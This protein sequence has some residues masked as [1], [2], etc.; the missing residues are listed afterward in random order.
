M[1]NIFKIEQKT[2]KSIKWSFFGELIVKLISPIT[3]MV[4]ARLLAPEVFGIVATISIVIALSE[5]LADSGFSKAIVQ[6][7]YKTKEDYSKSTTTAFW[8]TLGISLLIFVIVAIFR[9]PI[10]YL[11]GSPGY[12]FALLIASI[13][14][15]IYSLSSVHLSILR[16]NFLF[17][18]IFWVRFAAA[19]VPLAFGTVLALIRLSYWSLIIS[20]LASITIQSVLIIFLSKW[21][22]TLSFSFPHLKSM[23][24]YSFLNLLEALLVWVTASIDLVIISYVFG[25]SLTGMYRLSSTTVQALVRLVTAVF[26][27]VLFSS[28]S[29][30]KDDEF[31]FKQ[32]F[33]K[34]QRMVAYILLPIGAGVFLFRELATSLFFGNGW[35]RISLVVGLNALILSFKVPIND[36]ASVVYF[37]KGKPLFS[38]F[39]QIIYLGVL[40]VVCFVVPNYGFESFV[41]FRGLSPLILVI[42]SIIFLKIFFGIGIKE[43]IGNILPAFVITAIMFVVGLLLKNLFVGIWWDTIIIMICM[44]VYFS[45]CY[46]LFRKDVK[47]LLNFL[48]KKESNGDNGL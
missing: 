34:F 15:P 31:A 35:E 1:E 8:S 36:L 39:S 10:S 11:V 32:M 45:L 48:F 44:S 13:Q 30:L 16:R 41:F 2:S 29:R 12:G 9:N 23:F 14:M 24:S 46:I 42:S 38:I 19:I 27:P 25:D 18:K 3:N 20:S 4:L 40:L 26:V 43:E 17:K 33:S 21:R 5:L 22:P 37:S 28:L 7:D 6:Q 47:T